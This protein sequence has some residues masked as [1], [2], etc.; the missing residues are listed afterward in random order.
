MYFEGERSLLRVESVA[1]LTTDI[2]CQSAS[3]VVSLGCIRVPHSVLVLFIVFVCR[4][5]FLL[6]PF[7]PTGSCPP[8]DG[9]IWQQLCRLSCIRRCFRCPCE[10]SALK[11]SP[12]LPRCR[13]GTRK[14]GVVAT[15]GGLVL[16]CPL[17]S[18]PLR[19]H[20][21]AIVLVG[22]HRGELPLLLASLLSAPCCARHCDLHESA[23]SG[24]HQESR[25][26]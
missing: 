24:D 18:H 3:Q 10:L 16:V 13:A 8:Q 26:I 14:S 20:H 1:P 12:S 15:V 19:H 21:Q 25:P 22:T 17:L 11:R 2:L 23:L 6:F 5:D 7:C 4:L 9:P